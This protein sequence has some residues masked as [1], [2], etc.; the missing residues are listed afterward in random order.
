MFYRSESTNL[1]ILVLIDTLLIF[2]KEVFK[3]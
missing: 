2:L 3:F 1:S